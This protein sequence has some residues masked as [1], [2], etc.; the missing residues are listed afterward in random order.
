MLLE[1]TFVDSRIPPTVL[2]ASSQVRRFSKVSKRSK[3]G[4]VVQH[5]V[6]ICR[7]L[8]F[9][10]RV[11]FRGFTLVWCKPGAT[12]QGLDPESMLVFK[13]QGL[14]SYFATRM[15]A[16]R[17]SYSTHRFGDIE[18]GPSIS[19]VSKVDK[20]SNIL[21]KSVNLRAGSGAASPGMS[22][23]LM[24][25]LFE[26]CVGCYAHLETAWWLLRV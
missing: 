15:H 14:V 19:N 21:S 3:S 24:H 6:E 22:Q 9:E 8:H 1:C 11:L 18:S 2:G 25:Y 10:V 26:R 7:N 12:Y 17:F 16:C 13:W 20:L 5:T 4:Q 23:T